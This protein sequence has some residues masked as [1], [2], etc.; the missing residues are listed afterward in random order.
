MKEAV[1]SDKNNYFYKL[2]CN[3]TNFIATPVPTYSKKNT[4]F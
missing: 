1:V 3:F 2:Y 4:K